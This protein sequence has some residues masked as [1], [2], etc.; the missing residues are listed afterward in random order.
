MEQTKQE[1][2]QGGVDAGFPLGS[3]N[4]PDEEPPLLGL[5]SLQ[6]PRTAAA[7]QADPGERAPEGAEGR[8][9]RDSDMKYEV[10]PSAMLSRHF[11]LNLDTRQ[12]F[13]WFFI[14]SLVVFV[15]LHHKFALTL[16][17]VFLQDLQFSGL[18]KEDIE[19]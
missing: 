6:S 18:E 8:K 11:T 9:G 17:N 19:R 2:G 10:G 14:L 3:G 13:G 15:R 1:E 4:Q 16:T 7:S 12:R 5:E